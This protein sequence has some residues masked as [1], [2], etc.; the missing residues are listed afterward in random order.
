[1]LLEQKVTTTVAV[2]FNMDPLQPRDYYLTYAGQKY[3]MEPVAGYKGKYVCMKLP[4]STLGQYIDVQIFTSASAS[5]FAEGTIF[6]DRNEI[7]PEKKPT[8]PGPYTH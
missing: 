1:V 5:P 3:V 6:L 4:G 8:P 2:Y 7:S